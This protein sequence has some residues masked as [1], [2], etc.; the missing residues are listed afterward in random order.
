MIYVK[1]YTPVSWIALPALFLM[2]GVATA[3]N[4]PRLVANADTVALDE[5]FTITISALKPMQPVTIRAD[6]ENGRWHSSVALQADQTGRVKVPDP[7]MLVWSAKGDRRPGRAPTAADPWIFSAE[8][9]GLPVATDTVWRRA[10]APNVR[11]VRVRE[12]GLVGD[13]YYPAGAERH[14]AVIVLGGSQGGIPGPLAHAGGLA[15]HGYVVFA[16]GYFNAEGLPPFLKNIP[17]EYFGNAIERLKTDSLVD[18]RRIGVLGT[19]RGGE[20]ALLLGATYPSLRAVVANV[21]SNVVWPGL[22]DDGQTPAWTFEGKP[23]ASVPALFGPAD[24]LLSSRE[25]FLKRMHD[26]RAL[27]AAEIPVERINGP[28]LLFSAQD[29][30]VWPSDI[31][32]ARVVERLKKKRFKHPVEHYSYADAG[33]LITRPYLPTTNIREI[34]VHPVSHRKTMFGGTPEGQARAN[35]DSWQKLLAF[36]DK[37]LR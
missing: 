14:P 18:A 30:Q 36:L 9:D 23:L 15:S 13:L 11:V 3:Q 19:S 37:Y 16:L 4:A 10:V 22:S 12:N 34:T 8:V 27:R 26:T 17:L 25:R 6:G 21:P 20:L 29:D 35:E 32:A 2:A 24:S 1:G 33:H 7:M 31:F 28:V 5:P